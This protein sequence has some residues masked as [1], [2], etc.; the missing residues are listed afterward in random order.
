VSHRAFARFRLISIA[1]FVFGLVSV[2][3][4]FTATTAQE[5][6]QRVIARTPVEKDEPLGI[7]DVKVNGQSVTFGQKFNANDDWL[8][9]LVVTVKNTSDKRILFASIR[10][11]FP[12]PGVRQK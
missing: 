2:T 6:K 1:L 11:Q 5:A 7:T 8:K 9:S 12:R 10:L 4:A 3:V